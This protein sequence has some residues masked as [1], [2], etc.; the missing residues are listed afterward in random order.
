MTYV[1]DDFLI[2]DMQILHSL[3]VIHVKRTGFELRQNPFF[4]LSERP[5]TILFI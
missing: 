4:L 5:E 1:V 3:L 2:I